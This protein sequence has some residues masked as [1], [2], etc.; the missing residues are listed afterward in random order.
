[1][2]ALAHPLRLRLLGLLRTDGPGTATLLSP[3]VG[4]S[5][6]LVSYHLRQLAAHGFVEE[7]R[8]LARDARERWWRARHQMTSWDLGE[9][10]DSPER[11]AAGQALSSEVARRHAEVTAAWMSEMQALPREWVGA[12]DMSDQRLELFPEDVVELRRLLWDVIERFTD[13]PRREGTE[14]VQAILQLL[15]MPRNEPRR[16]PRSEDMRAT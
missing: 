15:P 7:A 10:L 9:L 12:W 16:E 11:L 3:L 13:R 1:M 2:R 6:P 5:V 4:K 14:P 8:D